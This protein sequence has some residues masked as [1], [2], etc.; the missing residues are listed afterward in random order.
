VTK[1]NGNKLQNVL[2]KM[3]KWV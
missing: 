2:P 1:S 3:K